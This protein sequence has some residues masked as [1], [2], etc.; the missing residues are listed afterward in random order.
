MLLPSGLKTGCEKYC[1]ALR[2]Q[3]IEVRRPW[4]QSSR[5][6][7]PVMSSLP[8]R[9]GAVWLGPQSPRDAP[10]SRPAGAR[11]VRPQAASTQTSRSTCI[12]A[13]VRVRHG[14]SAR[15]LG[16]P[17]N[18]VGPDQVAQT[19]GPVADQVPVDDGWRRSLS[20][21]LLICPC[22]TV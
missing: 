16:T 18:P 17:N 9:R 8:G 14:S 3:A 10:S 15:E 21:P 2:I 6:A 5:L 4:S 1:G 13:A 11:F 7:L 12:V 19:A 20:V 22:E